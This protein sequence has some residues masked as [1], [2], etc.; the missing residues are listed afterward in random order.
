MINNLKVLIVIPSRLGGFR[1]PDKALK[2]I[3]GKEMLLWVWESAIKSKYADKVVVATPDQKIKHFC[4]QNKMSVILTRKNHIRG[5]LR[6]HEAFL[7]SMPEA[8]IIINL[9][10]DEPCVRSTS[11]DLAI[12]KLSKNK[13]IAAVNL[14]NEISYQEADKDKNEVKVVTNK[15]NEALYFSRNALPAIWLGDKRFLCKK[16]ICVM[17]MWKWSLNKYAKLK[18]T[19]YEIIESVDMM[20]F[21]ENDYKILMVKC[22]ENI[23]SVDCKKDLIIAEKIL[24]NRN[25]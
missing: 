12:R 22:K 13:K 4:L 5:T 19:P 2:K 21:I 9:Q 11:I 7:K 3:N 1:F 17:P 20:R 25:S 8:D 16:E 18:Q 10:G 6:V 23:K 15:K 24:K 14:F